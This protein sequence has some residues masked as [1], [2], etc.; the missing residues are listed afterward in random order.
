MSLT[1]FTKVNNLV[2]M[3]TMEYNANEQFSKAQLTNLNLN[4]LKMIEALGLKKMHPG[5]LQWHYLH[6]KIYEDLPSGSRFINGW[7]TDR[8][9][10][11]Q[12]DRH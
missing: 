9:T 4:N 12:T 7:H 6:T 11:R 5:P 3:D 8:Q 1:E 10:D 2:A